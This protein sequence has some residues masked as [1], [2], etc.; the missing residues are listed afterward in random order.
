MPT[1][2]AFACS[3]CGTECGSQGALMKH[4]KTCV[5]KRN[6]KLHQVR[7]SIES[8]LFNLQGRITLMFGWAARS[9]ASYHGDR[10]THARLFH[11]WLN[12]DL[13]QATSDARTLNRML[14]DHSHAPLP[15]LSQLTN[16]VR[17]VLEQLADLKVILET[18]TSVFGRP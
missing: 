9:F 1:D 11:R 17:L 7:E 18:L 3:V 4:D 13:S 8:K 5:V 12:E 6:L 15:F 2:P 16:D 10:M 14:L